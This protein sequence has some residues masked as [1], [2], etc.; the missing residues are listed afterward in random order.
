M[1]LHKYLEYL[2]LL[3]RIWKRII[4]KLIDII[5]CLFSVWFAYFLRLGEFFSFNRQMAAASVV[6]IITLQIVLNT[7]KSYSVII[8]YFDIRSIGRLTKSLSIYAIVYSCVF[9]VI[10]YEGIPRTIGIIQPIILLI[11]I[12]SSRIIACYVFGEFYINSKNHPQYR[13]I[14]YGAGMQGREF[15]AGIGKSNDFKIVGFVDDDPKLHGHTINGL[16]VYR[17]DDLE[18][19]ISSLSLNVIFLASTTID[20]SKKIEL[21]NNLSHLNVIVRNV[22]SL[23]RLA[24]GKTSFNNVCDLDI[25]DLLGREEIKPREELL[26]QNVYNKTVLVTGAGGSI[27]SELSRQIVKI[28]PSRLILLDQNEFGL[29]SIE[30]ELREICNDLTEIVPILGSILDT[31]RLNN[32]FQKFEPDTIYHAAAY[33]HVPLVEQNCSAAVSNNV[34]GTLNLVQ[35]AIEYKSATFVL[36]STDKAV[37]PTNIMG[38]TKRLAEQIVQAYANISNNTCFSIVRFGNVLDSSGSVVPT[39]RKQ[40]SE[41]GPL[42]ITHPNVTRYFMTIPEAALLVIQA[43]AMSKTGDLFLLDMGIPVKILELAKKMI[44]LSGMHLYD[45]TTGE[46]DIK[47]KFIGLRPGEKLYEELLIDSDA[48]ATVHPRIWKAREDFLELSVLSHELSE[49]TVLLEENNVEGMKCIFEKLVSGYNRIH[50]TIDFLSSLD[51]TSKCDSFV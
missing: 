8:K 21:I 24:H 41:G 25:D 42:T 36:V 9:T 11:L 31:K 16:L 44:L 47:I 18:S 6:S 1:I 3:P 51:S 30:A 12:T 26:N 37:R 48:L 20:R 17:N 19:L 34:F 7:T 4:L 50:S 38:A 5:L 15:A 22:P 13:A 23:T 32:L 49:L 10:S 45:D 43:G 27:G 35:A 46:G 14:I 33:K 40:I 2:N 29:F 28:K 39:F